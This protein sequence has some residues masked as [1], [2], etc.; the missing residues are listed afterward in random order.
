MCARAYVRSLAWLAW[1][2]LWQRAGAVV[3]GVVVGV[4]GVVSWR[5]PD[6]RFK[7]EVTNG[8]PFGLA[9]VFVALQLRVAPLCRRGANRIRRRND[10][11]SVFV[12]AVVQV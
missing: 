5:D 4:V 10:H 6:G 9:G 7:C 11:L 1:F 12:G 3:V 8:Q 2:P